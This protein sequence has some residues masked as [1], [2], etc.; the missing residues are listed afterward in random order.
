MKEST[1]NYKTR[2]SELI[3]D[4]YITFDFVSCSTSS[5]AIRIMNSSVDKIRKN[6]GLIISE[7]TTVFKFNIKD[8]TEWS[9]SFNSFINSNQKQLNSLGSSFYLN[10]AAHSFLNEFVSY[11]HG[12]IDDLA[13]KCF[14][15]FSLSKYCPEKNCVFIVHGHDKKLKTFLNKELKKNGF[16]SI[17]LSEKNDTGITLFDKFEKYA[18][19]CL[20][21][22]ILMTKDDLIKKDDREYYQPRPNVLIELGY[23]LN[24]LNREDII[25]ISEKGCEFPSDIYGV[26]YLEYDSNL[27]TL[28]KKVLE[29]LN[30]K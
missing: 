12:Y 23:F 1:S 18:N 26:S 3:Q 20:K 19:K 6:Y 24:M 16:R 27:S 10:N 21:A 9:S 14:N 28:A 22:I 15:K 13:S 8:L 25:V 4:C 2:I 30:S 17:I 29:S 11:I 7:L 5:D